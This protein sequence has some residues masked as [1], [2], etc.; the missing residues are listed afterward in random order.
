VKPLA[1]GEGETLCWLNIQRRRMK[2]KKTFR[3]KADV[4][5]A[6]KRLLKGISNIRG[7]MNNIAAKP[8]GLF[9]VSQWLQSKIKARL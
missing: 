9:C 3:L 7:E 2:V 4:E 6:F 5:W 8:I 1:G